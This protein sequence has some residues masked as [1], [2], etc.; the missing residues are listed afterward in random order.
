[1]PEPDLPESVL[2]AATGPLAE[3]VALT[4]RRLGVL[5][6]AVHAGQGAPYGDEELLLGP[7]DAEADPVAVVEAARQ[8]RAQ[9]V[10]PAGGALCADPVAA[11]AVLDAGLVWVG[12]PPQV[13]ARL[14]AAAGG[15]S[16]A[17]IPGTLGPPGVPLRDATAL[18]AA[19][20]EVAVVDAVV[21]GERVLH[22]RLP[23]EATTA[24]LQQ[25]GAVA[26]RLG[27]TGPA[28]LLLDRQRE[29]LAVLPG[30]PADPGLREQAE[31][32]AG[33]DLVEHE[34]RTAGASA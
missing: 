15:R 5:A 2:V 22:L 31:L 28:R 30:P 23:G 19:A 1:M 20:P 25:V 6:V 33:L 4:C 11:Q 29:L 18:E 32:A 10:H 26:R 27:L 13:L 8:S 16:S 9:A 34:L 3:H 24:D 7:G 12:E 17:V 14:P 21:L